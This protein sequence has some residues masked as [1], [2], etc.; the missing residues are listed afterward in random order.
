LKIS[1]NIQRHNQNDLFERINIPELGSDSNQALGRR[2]S[3][4]PIQY[5]SAG[6]RSIAKAP[7]KSLANNC[8]S[9]AEKIGIDAKTEA[10]RSARRQDRAADGSDYAIR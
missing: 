10:D 2:R 4:K 8:N 9:T 6:F 3:T 7:G 5:G 1:A